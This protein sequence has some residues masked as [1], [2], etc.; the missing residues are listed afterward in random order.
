MA[1]WS[2]PPTEI[3]LLI[4]RQYVDSLLTDFTKFPH[5]TKYK[6]D[7]ALGQI[8][9]LAQAI[10]AFCIDILECLYI[11]LAGSVPAVADGKWI[12]VK[13]DWKL[14][15][16]SAFRNDV[17]DLLEHWYYWADL[18]VDG[19]SID[20]RCSTYWRHMKR[21]RDMAEVEELE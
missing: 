9:N 8:C 2:D 15:S 16:W 3:K 12:A 19:T 11:T 4:L 18:Q 14:E 6:K 13:Q 7:N 20:E 5:A 17:E 21:K 1:S 10:P